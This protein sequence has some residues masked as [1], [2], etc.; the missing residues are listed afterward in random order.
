MMHNC[1]LFIFSLIIL[2]VGCGINDSEENSVKDNKVSFSENDY[3]K[4]VLSSNKLGFELIRE[5]E[6]DENDNAF[7][8][9]ASLY[10]LLSIVH[11]G[12]EGKTKEEM[13]Q[14]LGASKLSKNDINKA[15]ASLLQLLSKET[16]HVRVDIGNSLWLNDQYSFQD[17]FSHQAKSYFN[18]KIEEV[19]M[20][21]S[22]TVDR[23][24]R[25]VKDATKEKIEKIVDGPLDVQTV[26]ILVNAIYFNGDWKYT[27]DKSKTKQGTFRDEHGNTNKLDFMELETKLPYFETKNFQAVSLPYGDEEVSMNIFLPK[28]NKSLAHFLDELSENNWEK[29]QTSFKKKEGKVIFPKFE[30]EYETELNDALK[31]LGMNDAFSKED[32]NFAD[33]IHEEEQIY[34][35]LLKQKTYI[36]IHE[37]GTEAAAVT[38]AEIR[39]TSAPVDAPFYLEVNRP[40]LFTITDDETNII[41]F[42]GAIQLPS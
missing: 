13:A 8:S 9:P 15:N 19:S 27:F 14:V 11:N 42:M 5:V 36:D 33:M 37:E 34:L 22:Q 18:G 30:L 6:R 26:T 28:E 16:E 21:D 41:L 31:M 25:W 4:I 12:A 7:I 1:R 38:S 39:L 35:D 10:M 24:N 20:D 29:W 40:F 17:E 2:L 23:I 32:A 3:E